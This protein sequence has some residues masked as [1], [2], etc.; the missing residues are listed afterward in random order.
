MHENFSLVVE[1]EEIFVQICHILFQTI[2]VC[3]KQTDHM[4]KYI[5]QTFLKSVIQDI[6]LI[7]A[8]RFKWI[9]HL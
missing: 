5:I 6:Y 1:F 9:S 2:R 8:Y 3:V 4:T 7:D